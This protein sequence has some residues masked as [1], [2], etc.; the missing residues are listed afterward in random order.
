MWIWTQTQR[1]KETIGKYKNL[2]L[3]YL[4]KFHSIFVDCKMRCTLTQMYDLRLYTPGGALDSQ[5]SD[6]RCIE[7]LV[8]AHHNCM[9]GYRDVG[10]QTLPSESGIVCV[11]CFG[12]KAH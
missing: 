2:K 6:S 10:T 3:Q 5:T 7:S 11:I 8:R 1:G 4:S 9:E 12:W